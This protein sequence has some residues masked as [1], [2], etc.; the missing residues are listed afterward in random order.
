MWHVPLI[1]STI[2]TILYW[3]YVQHCTPFADL[4]TIIAFVHMVYHYA[5]IYSY[6][7][8]LNKKTLISS[9]ILTILYWLDVQY[10]TPFAHLPLLL[11][12]LC[13]T[14]LTYAYAIHLNKKDGENSNPKT[15]SSTWHTH[16]WNLYINTIFVGTIYKINLIHKLTRCITRYVQHH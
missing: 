11:Y 1:L 13:T 8:H 6:V 14:M 12:T 3:P 7:I 16:C 15:H 4:L 2:L 9:I 10:C 5:H